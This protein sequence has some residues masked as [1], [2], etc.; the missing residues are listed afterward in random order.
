VLA[1]LVGV[2]AALISRPVTPLGPGSPTLGPM[3]GSQVGELLAL[4]VVIGFGLWL[5]FTLRDSSHRVPYPPRAVVTILVVLL[6]GVLF[7]ELSGIV[8]IAPLP[9]SSN[10][11]GNSSPPPGSGTNGSSNLTSP[12][13]GF[14]SVTLPAWAGIV[15]VIGLSILIAAVLIPF[16]L[17]RARE[18]A[19][20]WSVPDGRR[21]V[22]AQRA[23]TEALD[24]LRG[25][26]DSEARAAILALYARLLTS[27]GSRLGPVE[28]RTVRE[29]ERAAIETLGLRPTAARELTD[30]FEEARYSSHRM[31]A[32]AVGRARTALTDALVDMARSPGGPT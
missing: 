22:E 16:L 31:S 20:G 2:A 6:L 11:T 14:P 3:T 23:L 7:V 21:S 8:H 29:I 32:E 10:S 28:P 26:E 18:R 19:P 15:T 27:V 4:T 24:R 13:G 12:G 1:V 17:A 30:V 25:G 9:G 5:F